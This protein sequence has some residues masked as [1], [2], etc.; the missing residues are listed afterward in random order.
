MP[1]ILSASGML[2]RRKRSEALPQNGGGAGAAGTLKLNSEARDPLGRG[3]R[4][5]AERFLR[6]DGDVLSIRSEPSHD[7]RREFGY[8]ERHPTEAT[9]PEPEKFSAP[10]RG[11]H[12]QGSAAAVLL[13][14]TSDRG[15]LGQ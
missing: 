8:H 15:L 6:H 12:E 11:P 14:A 1:G 13:G 3:P 10:G 9:H 5:E 4:A 2:S 7:G